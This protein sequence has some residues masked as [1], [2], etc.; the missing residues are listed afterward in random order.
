MY[1]RPKVLDIFHSTCKK[2]QTVNKSKLIKSA[3]QIVNV[4]IV[5]ICQMFDVHSMQ[6]SR[7][8]LTNQVKKIWHVRK[9][10]QAI[11]FLAKG[12]FFVSW[13]RFFIFLCPYVGC[14]CSEKRIIWKWRPNWVEECTKQKV[15]TFAK[16]LLIAFDNIHFKFFLQ[17]NI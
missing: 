1:T 13:C 11:M 3:T 14:N 15:F 17:S 10:S 4:V 16:L 9:F 6:W 8:Q 12:G 7:E 5:H 2:Q